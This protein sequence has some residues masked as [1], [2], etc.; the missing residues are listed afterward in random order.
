MHEPSITCGERRGT[1][2]GAAAHR[3]AGEYR[4]PACIRGELEYR[5][6]Y[7]HRVGR[8]TSTK[9]SDELLADLLA[10]ATDRLRRKVADEIGEPLLRQLMAKAGR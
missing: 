3:A 5:R 6:A 8:L 10:R 1:L 2:A 7:D 9:L 4:C